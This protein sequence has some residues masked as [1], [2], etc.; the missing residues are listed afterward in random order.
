MFSGQ[1]WQKKPKQIIY[2]Q[3]ICVVVINFCLMLL[4]K[5]IS[6]II[7][8]LTHSNI[9]YIIRQFEVPVN[10]SSLGITNTPERHL[11]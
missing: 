6:F 9:Y 7:Q 11:R 4:E 3:F 1:S 8:V 5:V 2:D 10:K